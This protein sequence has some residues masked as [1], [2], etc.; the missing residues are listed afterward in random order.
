V[1]AGRWPFVDDGRQRL[2]GRNLQIGG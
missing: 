1:D 2:G